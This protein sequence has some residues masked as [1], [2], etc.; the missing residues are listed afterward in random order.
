MSDI[1]IPAMQGTWTLVGTIPKMV[2]R[3]FIHRGRVYTWDTFKFRY[4]CGC[5]GYCK[6]WKGD[7]DVEESGFEE[8]EE[9]GD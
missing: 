9:S 1:I 4:C 6:S 8:R 3:W 2:E 7:D 5:V